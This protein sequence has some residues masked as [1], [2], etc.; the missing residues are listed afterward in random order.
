MPGAGNVLR[1]I[2]GFARR[3]AL[4]TGG[5]GLVV[6]AGLGAY[7]ADPGN[8]LYGAAIGAGIGGIGGY[9]GMRAVGKGASMARFGA[10]GSATRQRF[11]GLQASGIRP[12]SKSWGRRELAKRFPGSAQQGAAR[13]S[14]MSEIRNGI[15]SRMSSLSR[16]TRGVALAGYLGLSSAAANAS[17]RSRPA[18]IKNLSRLEASGSELKDRFRRKFGIGGR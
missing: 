5:A 13:S 18:M 11:A 1:G 2:S 15:H 12:M 7:N 14:F 4:R 10:A 8:R 3:N 9:A 17:M 6:G 16:S